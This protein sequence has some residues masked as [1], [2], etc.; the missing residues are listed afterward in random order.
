MAKVPND[1]EQLRLLIQSTLDYAI[2]TL[3]TEGRVAN[4]NAGAQRLKG[5]APEEIIGEH[6]RVFYTP[7]AQATRHPEAELERAAAEGRYEEEGWR[8]RKDGTRYWASV[9]ITAL[10]GEDGTLRGFGKVTRDLTERKQAERRAVIGELAAGVAHELG[11]PLGVVSNAHYLL[12]RMLEAREDNDALRPLA[13]AERE[14]ASATLIVSDLLDFAEGREPR[15][16]LVS[17]DE[18][19]TEAVSVAPP[20]ARVKIDVHAGAGLS[21]R[22]DRDLIRQA[23]LNTI[24]NAYEAM[25]GGTGTVRVLTEATDDGV[26]IL[27]ADSGSGMDAATAERAFEPLFSGKTRGLG[28]GLA[29]VRRIVESHGGTVTLTSVPEEGTTVTIDLPREGSVASEG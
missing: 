24:I 28:L 10:R 29:V 8:L 22:A 23:L 27:V 3:D 5:Y 9:V 17:I 13:T 1:A 20:P 25:P 7:E 2:F 19:V 4:W 26:R 21:I 12:R 18:L 14:V 11:N 15:P 16:M 6:F